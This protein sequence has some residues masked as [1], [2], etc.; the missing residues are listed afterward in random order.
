MLPERVGG[1]LGETGGL[2]VATNAVRCDRVRTEIEP[3]RVSS[4]DLAAQRLTLDDIMHHRPDDGILA[5]EGVAAPSNSG[6]TWIVDP[7]DGTTN[8]LR[9]YPG[10]R[11]A[12]VCGTVMTQ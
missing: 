7:L 10:W 8:Y 12:S 6:L 3:D 2:G 11:S 5:E 4:A 9:G 1:A